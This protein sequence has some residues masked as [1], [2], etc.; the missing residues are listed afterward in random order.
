MGTWC[1]TGVSAAVKC[2]KSIAVNDRLLSA[3]LLLHEILV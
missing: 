3:N 1:L 2:L